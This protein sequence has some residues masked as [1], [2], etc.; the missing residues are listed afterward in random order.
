MTEINA[1][2]VKELR[3][4]TGSGMMDCK[5]ALVECAGNFEEA[6]DWLRKK[7]LA[8]AGKK[9]DRVTSEGLVAIALS[10][11]KAIAIELNSETDFV[12]QNDKFKNL[13]KGLAEQALKYN[14]ITVQELLALS[15]PFDSSRTI[16]EE[17]TEHIAV[18]GENITLRRIDNVEINSGVIGSYVH[19]ASANG[20]GK[21]AVL[22]SLESNSSSDEVK[23]L[24][25]H[26][27]MHIAAAK[28]SSLNIE[29][30]DGALIE[31]E[32]AIFTDQAIASGKPTAV[33]EKM[34]EGRIRKFYEEIVLLEQIY[35]IDGKTKVSQMIADVAKNSEIKVTK[36]I[37]SDTTVNCLLNTRRTV[38]IDQ[39]I[40]IFW[41]FLV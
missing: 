34:V 40:A 29:Q 20:M 9:A 35:A 5:K 8:A 18:I 14:A 21:I 31:R 19:N 26:L 37:Q 25:K 41:R 3:D 13:A 12:A 15:S 30:L 39:R 7:G 10:E 33:I 22:I 27:A 32:K 38:S 1:N 36:F 23:Q 16:K 17:I 2:M 11:N 24:A 4:K 6:I 28:P